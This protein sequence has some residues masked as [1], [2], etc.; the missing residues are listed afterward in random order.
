MRVK[1]E[2]GINT[3]CIEYLGGQRFIEIQRAGG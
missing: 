3:I 2:L 1:V